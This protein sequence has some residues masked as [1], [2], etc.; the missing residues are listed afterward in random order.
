MTALGI[1][2]EACESFA[3]EGKEA[4]YSNRSTNV[5]NRR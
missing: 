1:S 2:A 3:S 4:P 5:E